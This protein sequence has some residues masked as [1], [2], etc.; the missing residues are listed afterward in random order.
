MANQEHVEILKQG[1]GVW[2]QWRDEHPEIQPDFDEANLEG[3]HL[4]QA[5]LS[6]ANF[7][8][9]YLFRTFLDE[10]NL[11]DANLHVDCRILFRFF[12]SITFHRNA[13]DQPVEG[14]NTLSYEVSPDI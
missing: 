9:A 8:R 2:N 5:D 11:Y 1:V 10:S 12:R 4:S 13:F 6:G 14:I 3:T 7:R